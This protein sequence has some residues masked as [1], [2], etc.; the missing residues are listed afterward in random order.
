MDQF[1]ECFN[2][3]LNGA[4]TILDDEFDFYVAEL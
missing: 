1:I 4:L 2:G 3:T